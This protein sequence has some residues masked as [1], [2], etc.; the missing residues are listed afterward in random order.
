METVPKCPHTDLPIAG[1]EKL[2]QF[3]SSTCL[4]LRVVEKRSSRGFGQKRVLVL[5]YTNL[6]LCE[7]KDPPKIK[8]FVPID[9][10]REVVYFED[11]KT[12]QL[13][14]LLKF[15][16]TE[17]NNQRHDECDLMFSQ[18]SDPRNGALP[19]DSFL[20]VLRKILHT[21]GVSV[22]YFKAPSLDRLT[23]EAQL[24]KGKAEKSQSPH[25]RLDVRRRSLGPDGSDSGSPL[26]R[27]LNSFRSRSK[28]SSPTASLSPSSPATSTQGYPSVQGKN[29]GKSC[30]PV[31]T[32]F[33]AL[34]SEVGSPNESFNSSMYSTAPSTSTPQL[35]PP[36][37]KLSGVFSAFNEPN[38][39]IRYVLSLSGG[40]VFILSK[41]KKNK[42]LKKKN[43]KK[44]NRYARIVDVTT[45][46]KQTQRA[47]L[48]ITGT[49]I[50]FATVPE[51]AMITSM[52]FGQL[53][54]IKMVDGKKIIMGSITVE[55]VNDSRNEY[56]G[57][58]TVSE[59]N[60]LCDLM[61]RIARAN[62]NNLR[63]IRE[64]ESPIPS[65]GNT[66]MGS[67]I[68]ILARPSWM[69][70]L[71]DTE[72]LSFMRM[73]VKH[74]QQ[75][76]ATTNRLLVLTH[77]ALLV[78]LPDGSEIKS[79]LHFSKIQEILYASIEG[80]EERPY[81]QILVRGNQYEDDILFSQCTRGMQQEVSQ[82]RFI[83]VA[84]AVWKEIS[85]SDVVIIRKVAPHE[86]Q[87]LAD[88]PLERKDS[89]SSDI[90]SPMRLNS[91]LKG[92]KYDSGES[93]PVSPTLLNSATPLSLEAMQKLSCLERVPNPPNCD[94]SLANCIILYKASVDRHKD[95]V[96]PVG[97]FISHHRT[98]IVTAHFIVA[99]D[100]TQPSGR[101]VKRFLPHEQIKE[102]I[103]FSTQHFLL[104]SKIGDPDMW[105]SVTD[106]DVPSLLSVL[107]S[108]LQA[109]VLSADYIETQSLDE[110]RTHRTA[111]QKRRAS[112]APYALGTECPVTG[113]AAVILD[114]DK[115]WLSSL[116]S[117][118][119]NPL[120]I[121]DCNST[122]CSVQCCAVLTAST[123]IVAMP[124]GDPVR[125][126]IVHK[127]EVSDVV[128]F[129]FTNKTMGTVL[130]IISSSEKSERSTG[131]IALP[132]DDKSFPSLLSSLSTIA[133]KTSPSSYIENRSSTNL[134][135]TGQVICFQ[136]AGVPGIPSSIQITSDAGILLRSTSDVI[137][138]QLQLKDVTRMSCPHQS[139]MLVVSST[140]SDI[141]I[142]FESSDQSK[143][144]SGVLKNVIQSCGFNLETIQVPS[145]V[146]VMSIAT[147]GQGLGNPAVPV[148][149][150]FQPV[151]DEQGLSVSSQ[152]VADMSLQSV[153]SSAAVN[154]LQRPVPE[155]DSIPLS[156]QTSLVQQA[157][158]QM[159][160]QRQQSQS[161]PNQLEGNPDV[162]SQVSSQ[163]QG[164]PQMPQ[165]D[166]PQTPK[167]A[168]GTPQMPPQVY[169]QPGTPQMPQQSQQQV[170]LPQSDQPQ[171]SPQIT[172]H[173]QDQ[174][175]I[176]QGTPQ[177]VPQTDQMFP[178]V[179]P[180]H[181]GTPQQGQQGSTQVIPQ[182]QQ[183]QMIPHVDHQRA[184][185]AAQNQ[186]Q[187]QVL[188]QSD[189]QETQQ[190]LS[191][192][193]QPQV[194]SQSNQREIEQPQQVIPQPTNDH[195]QGTRQMP[196]QNQGTP[197]IPPLPSTS[198]PPVV[199]QVSGQ[200]QF[201][202]GTPQGNTHLSQTTQSPAVITQVF[203]ASQV[204]QR[205]GQQTPLMLP[206]TSSPTHTNNSNSDYIN[207][208]SSSSSDLILKLN[209]SDVKCNE[210]QT[211]VTHIND[212]L[213]TTKL[214][215]QNTEKQLRDQIKQLENNAANNAANNTTNN[216]TNS[217]PAPSQMSDDLKSVLVVCGVGENDLSKFEQLA[218][219]G[220]KD[221]SD[222]T[223]SELKETGLPT[224]LLR[225][226][227]RSCGYREGRYDGSC[228]ESETVPGSPYSSASPGSPNSI[229]SERSRRIAH[230]RLRIVQ[231]EN[232]SLK[233]TILILKEQIKVLRIQ[234]GLP[235]AS[236]RQHS[237]PA[238]RLS[239]QSVAEVDVMPVSL[240]QKLHSP[241]P[242]VSVN[243]ITTNGFNL[244][245][246]ASLQT[247]FE[248]PEIS[249]PA[250]PV[251]T[252]PAA[253]NH[254]Q[255]TV[256]EST[257][258][259]SSDIS[260]TDASH[261]AVELVDK[262]SEE[263]QS[264][265]VAEQVTAVPNST[266]LSED[267]T[268]LQIQEE[269]HQGQQQALIQHAAKAA[270]DERNDRRRRLRE[271]GD[272]PIPQP[273]AV[274]VLCVI[275]CEYLLYVIII[276][277]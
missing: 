81:F 228:C 55:L 56:T 109:R 181:Q 247:D 30:P 139:N 117:I 118:Y 187:P 274:C 65:R 163:L 202:M 82:S 71:P 91:A 253:Q 47:A 235:P 103:Y 95:V 152:N 28:S 57:L 90:Q 99:C 134:K 264:A 217:N 268:M 86:L 38:H 119:G 113:L 24:E 160:L 43:K 46:D 168:Q 93:P 156:S 180:E 201:Q 185:Q 177:V 211:L 210:L 141:V 237:L 112:I 77:D 120:C 1:L 254:Q 66:P 224:P 200:Q 199:P 256:P 175:V 233:E 116:F 32:A 26:S 257:E 3:K 83:E 219:R 183:S 169:G 276:Y 52:K 227:L 6:V 40:C 170:I 172:P 176:T 135:C 130:S 263:V 53:M 164:T 182:G 174:K 97:S 84:E 105:F 255:V 19:Q 80:V 155:N 266:S 245:S 127:A 239:S 226:V 259:K 269:Y 144:I 108:I 153:S 114:D 277:K 73:I 207:T 159:E 232:R 110:L 60:K 23:A 225:R 85:H 54:T 162:V 194:L 44:K 9:T 107:Q 13:S 212:E 89:R 48:L 17:R 191:Q 148:A 87:Q 29:R 121:I 188:S 167:N 258:V 4:F 206:Q 104:T 68:P 111:P 37:I 64:G 96:N 231:S 33:G 222:V 98:L 150:N 128:A 15:N 70:D 221:F 146:D 154:G 215:S 131:L 25:K 165:P 189:H 214:Q 236:V 31:D 147:F 100:L 75:S 138:E 36:P 204:A 7:L 171:V 123:F 252:S 22:K 196:S 261:N 229:E 192:G 129:Y 178:Q 209:A 124:E 193:Q 250:P 249:P 76:G 271:L 238:G 11:A 251:L 230:E 88:S 158:L 41:T 275:M 186:Q 218:I 92:K 273:S 173:P 260:Q 126:G 10:M 242:G 133:S 35:L 115:K 190:M 20:T 203:D 184:Q 248:T 101:Q 220:I 136:A 42:I 78:Y 142:Q 2:P 49:G 16:P 140:S 205:T 61:S 62:G 270:D 59:T 79:T 223:F 74:Q 179:V 143:F 198:T 166:Q 34:V 267:K 63:V 234:R 265:P 197:Q 272:L 195:S 5:R 18:C 122:T 21:R 67:K 246:I 50:N 72:T 157:G 262:T 94:Q 213:E 39:S 45:S 106:T 27:A 216:T 149:T 132:G 208:A 69:K 14:F 102:I 8:K 145:D 51:K 243:G 244:P 58:D 151:A 241:T 161:A 12:G 125:P 137:I 240:P